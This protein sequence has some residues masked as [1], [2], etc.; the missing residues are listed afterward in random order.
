MVRHFLEQARN[1]FTDQISEWFQETARRDGAALD[2]FCEAF[3]N[4]DAESAEKQLNHYLNKTISICDT[5]VKK[6]MKENFCYRKK[7]RIMLECNTI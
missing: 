6:D 7:C 4:G 3:G 1:V 5:A 2:A